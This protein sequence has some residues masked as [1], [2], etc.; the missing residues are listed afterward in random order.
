MAN[1]L[2]IV[3]PDQD[4]ARSASFSATSEQTGYEASQAG[5][6]DPSEP[7]W[8][9]SITATLTITLGASRLIDC[10]ALI[11]TNVDD[12]LVITIGGLSGGSQ[13]LVG[14]REASGY[15][16]DLVLLLDTPQTA[17]AITVAVS[18]NTNKV[19]IGRVVVGLMDQLPENLLLGVTVTPFRQQFS[20]EHQDFRHDLRYDIG[21]EGW[22]VEGDLL[23]PANESGN[24]PG[25]SA[26]AQLD[27]IWRATKAGYLPCVVVPHPTIY[28]P[29][30]A[31][32]TMELPRSHQHAPEIT[33][34]H[35][36]FTP[37]SRGLEVV[38]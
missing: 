38:G 34:T 11:M 16:R 2:I 1:G 28:P 4:W 17:T 10:I 31:R 12:G 7:W 25:E 22:L 37:V 15:P 8:A 18:G 9:D 19:S 36:R 20:D 14:A 26:Q 27:N 21:V 29:I 33:T 13:Q 6:E 32:F 35:L 3:R 30:F 5:T 23:S 24:S